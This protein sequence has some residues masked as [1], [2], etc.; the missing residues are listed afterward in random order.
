VS[1][2]YV[3]KTPAEAKR[4]HNLSIQH[5][6]PAKRRSSLL[7]FLHNHAFC[8]LRLCCVLAITFSERRIILSSFK[9]FLASHDLKIYLFQ[10]ER[11]KPRPAKDP[12][13]IVFTRPEGN[14]SHRL[15][16]ENTRRHPDEGREGDERTLKVL[17]EVSET[18]S[19]SSLVD[20]GFSWF[21]TY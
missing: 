14:Q 4:S 12:K 19:F 13:P 7:T 17:D 5:F 21:Y 6:Y 10:A 18:S 11:V 8:F 1:N 9:I 20:G 16:P 2:H 15:Q 3:F